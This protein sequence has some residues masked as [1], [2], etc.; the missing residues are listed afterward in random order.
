M[1][2]HYRTSAG[3]GNDKSFELG[4]ISHVL[5]EQKTGHECLKSIGFD[6]FEK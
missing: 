2:L 3:K 4:E 5:N 6:W 1:I